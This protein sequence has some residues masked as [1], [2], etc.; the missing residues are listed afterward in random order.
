[1]KLKNK[2]KEKLILR[3]IH[4]GF[5]PDKAEIEVEEF[6]K[7]AIKLIEDAKVESKKEKRKNESKNS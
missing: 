4:L 2:T 5:S 1:M 3:L 6:P 7:N